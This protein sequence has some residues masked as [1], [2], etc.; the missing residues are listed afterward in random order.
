MLE[1]I[2]S[3]FSNSAGDA[4]LQDPRLDSLDDMK[5][6]MNKVLSTRILMA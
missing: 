4:P 6:K 2:W 1:M 5:G 3:S